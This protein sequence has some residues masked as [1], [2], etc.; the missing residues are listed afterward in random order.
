M[1]ERWCAK[2]L[3][4]IF[5]SEGT[6]IRYAE[7]FIVLKSPD[8]PEAQ[9]EAEKLVDGI[10]EE[11]AKEARRRPKLPPEIDLKVKKLEIVGRLTPE[12]IAS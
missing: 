1:K 8:R 9:E 3:K 10:N 5:T 12:R 2:F 6:G 11:T 7:A 4:P